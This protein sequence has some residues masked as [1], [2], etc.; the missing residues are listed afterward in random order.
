MLDMI[1]MYTSFLFPRYYSEE[2]GIKLNQHGVDNHWADFPYQFDP[3][4]I[5]ECK[6]FETSNKEK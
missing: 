5:E 6:G 4:W 1:L 3:I 2:L